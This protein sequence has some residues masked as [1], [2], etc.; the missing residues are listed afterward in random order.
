MLPFTDVKLPIKW[1]CQDGNST[2]HESDEMKEGSTT[3]HFDYFL[4]RLDA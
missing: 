4:G 1:I 2:N 3:R